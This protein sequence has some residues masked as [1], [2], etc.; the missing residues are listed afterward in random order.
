MRIVDV[1]IALENL[2]DLP[3][4]GKSLT[5]QRRASGYLGT[6]PASRDRIK[7]SV[8]EFYNARSYIV[9]GQRGNAHPL[10]THRWFAS[11]FDIARRTLFKML[12]EGRPNNWDD[13]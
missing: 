4:R 3:Q 2:Y 8:K 7:Q 12:Y 9:H 1:A 10:E 6:A 5:L 11:G 13:L